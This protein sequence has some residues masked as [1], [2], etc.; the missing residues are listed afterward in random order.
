MSIV[1]WLSNYA[2]CQYFYADDV[3]NWWKLKCAIYNICI[4]LILIAL[5]QGSNIKLKLIINIG[6][7]FVLSSVIDR[8]VFGITDF[9]DKDYLMI[10][11]TIAFS[12][13]DYKK[14]KRNVRN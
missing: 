6:I 11:L 3:D 5:R 4:V 14:E 13:Y 10:A 7:G 9:V 1:L 8:L 2:L 12:I